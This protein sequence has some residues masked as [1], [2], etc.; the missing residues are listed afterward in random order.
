MRCGAADSRSRRTRHW[1]PP[2]PCAFDRNTD[3]RLAP[4]GAVEAEE[5]EEEGEDGA[6]EVAEVGTLHNGERVA[7]SEAA[8]RATGTEGML[9][10]GEVNVEE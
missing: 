3:Q 4:K 5:E 9:E 2:V 1:S 8:R 6:A 10:E 7:A